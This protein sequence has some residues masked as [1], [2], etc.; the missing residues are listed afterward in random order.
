MM[1]RFQ[2]LLS[3]STC[4]AALQT[5]G[6]GGVRVWGVEVQPPYRPRMASN[7]VTG[8][9]LARGSVG[10]V[11]TLNNVDIQQTVIAVSSYYGKR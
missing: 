3:V 11:C 5:H 2:A 8:D 4:A 1:N 9:S 10:S 6:G 7:G